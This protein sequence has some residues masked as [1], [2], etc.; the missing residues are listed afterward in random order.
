MRQNSNLYHLK[1]LLTM[2]NRT[3]Q[4]RNRRLA[5]A[6]GPRVLSE[7]ASLLSA[8]PFLYSAPRGDGH[9]VLVMPGFGAGDRSTRVIRGFLG[10]M[11][12]KTHPWKLGTNLGPVMSDLPLQLAERL[13]EVFAN[14][15]G[16]NGE[17]AVSLVGWSLGGVYA[18]L[19]AQLFPDK[20]RQ[21]ITLGSPFAAGSWTTSTHGFAR[22][23]RDIPL[24]Q[25]S[26][27]DL[28]LLA[29]ESLAN[30]PSTAIFSKTDGIVPWKIASQ[31]PSHIAE[32]IEVYSSHLGL[33]FNSAV[34][35]ALSDRLANSV[36]Q[37][38]PFKRS[39]WK[40]YVYGPAQLETDDSWSAQDSPVQGSPV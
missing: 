12:Y 6:E 40:S 36:G 8:A 20:V 24:E 19:L 33:G 27:N 3:Y 13:D 9:P 22:T 37:W 25:V 4:R 31:Q 35:Y 7:I 28:R 18:R 5:L 29:G 11:G 30:I 2:E 23:V 21:V 1:E 39:G 10:S 26:S 14:V 32:N 34:L 15:N 17:Q 38:R 16:N